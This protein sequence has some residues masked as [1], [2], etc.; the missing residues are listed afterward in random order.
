MKDLLQRL[1]ALKVRLE[2]DDGSLRVRAPKGV[3]TDELRQEIAE[4]KQELLFWL[5]Q[6]AAQGEADA[7]EAWSRADRAEAQPLGDAQLR[8]WILSQLVGEEADS[9]LNVLGSQNH[10]R[11]DLDDVLER[12]VGAEEEAAHLQAIDK[13]SGFCSSGFECRPVAHELYADE[14]A[15]TTNVAN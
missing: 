11:F 13:I 1:A 3:L 4:R 14:Q 5:S 15:H 2:A 9:H 6:H 10:W 12:A 7:D 8:I